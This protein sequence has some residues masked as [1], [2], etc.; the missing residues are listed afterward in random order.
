MSFVIEKEADFKYIHRILN[1]N[2][3]GKR[4]TPI[5]LTGIRGVGRRFAY[6]IC[7]VLK[8]DPHSRAGLLTED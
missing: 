3:D 7:R 6:I 5:A 1:T 4:I 2:I 8:I